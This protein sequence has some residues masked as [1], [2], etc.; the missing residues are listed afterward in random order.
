MTKN[1]MDVLLFYLLFYKAVD[2][3]LKYSKNLNIEHLNVLYAIIDY[4]KTSHQGMDIETLMKKTYLSKRTLLYLVSH[5]YHE[6]WIFKSY[7]ANAVS[8]THL[9]L[10]TKA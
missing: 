8:Y 10:P 4:H 5:L 6:N 3:L 9:T 7:D 1:D 2:E